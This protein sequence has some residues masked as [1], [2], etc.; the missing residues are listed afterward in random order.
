MFD[1]A[2]PGQERN[3]ITDWI[4]RGSVAFA[5]ILFGLEKFPSGPDAQWV[6]FFDQV[7]MGQWFRYFTGVVELGAATLVL[8]PRTARYGLALLAM[9][10]AVASVIHVFVIHQPAN[11]VITG[12][13]CL[14][15]SAFWWKLGER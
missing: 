5:F 15:L 6:R 14:G 13:L 1:N 2:T 4:L 12:G 9:T 11:V 10:M 3:R 8:F 7:G